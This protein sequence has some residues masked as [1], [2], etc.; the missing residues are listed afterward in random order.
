MAR[1][2]FR[3][4]AP[5]EPVIGYARGVRLANVI[6]ISG[7]AAVDESGVL[8][9]VGDVRLQAEQCLKNA[10]RALQA[11]DADLEDVARTRWFLKD[12]DDW[13]AVGEAHR[14]FFGDV[15]PACSMFEVSRL[16]T[17]EVLVELE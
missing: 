15:R 17:D 1:R 2:E 16:I 14:G 9:G 4:A 6:A 7:T 3:S 10:R 8:V 13:K 12:L 11:L 5:W